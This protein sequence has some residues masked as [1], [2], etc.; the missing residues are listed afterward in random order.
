MTV[1]G[2]NHLVTF[3]AKHSDARSTLSVWEKE[4]EAATWA[5]PSDLKLR[6]P[7]ASLVGKD[8][9]VFNIGG[10]RYRLHVR[11]NYATSIVIVVRIGTHNDY[12]QW[13]F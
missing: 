10:G 13:V 11:V 3:A 2:K 12:D 4:V 5:S 8:N 6:Y 1:L 9:V 7:K